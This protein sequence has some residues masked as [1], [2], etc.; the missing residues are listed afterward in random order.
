M[1]V[2]LACGFRGDPILTPRHRSGQA[3]QTIW[4]GPLNPLPREQEIIPP[5]SKGQLAP[6]RKGKGRLIGRPSY[7]PTLLPDG[8]VLGAPPLERGYL[9]ARASV[10]LAGNPSFRGS[11]YSRPMPQQPPI[12][13][14]PSLTHFFDISRYPAGSI[15]LAVP[16]LNR[17][18]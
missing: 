2:S 14:T 6:S 15:S 13:W 3:L 7:W 17:V 1:H 4:R 9:A 12:T 18:P 11:M 16:S 10:S 8:G 5:N